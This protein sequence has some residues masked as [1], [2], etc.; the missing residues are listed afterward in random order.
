MPLA[1]QLTAMDEML[2]SAAESAENALGTAANVEVVAT[3]VLLLTRSLKF[4]ASI[5]DCA[6]FLRNEMFHD[7]RDVVISKRTVQHLDFLIEC[8]EWARRCRPLQNGRV[9]AVGRFR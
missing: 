9:T 2:T 3:I 6:T 7:R 4:N 8:L 5:P 1:P